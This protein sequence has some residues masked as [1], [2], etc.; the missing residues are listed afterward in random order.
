MERYTSVE[1]EGVTEE[2]APLRLQAH[3]WQARILQHECDHVQVCVW[4]VGGVWGAVG[5]QLLRGEGR[6]LGGHHLGMCHPCSL[7]ISR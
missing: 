1:V 7:S 4:G 3:G 5:L 2:G 6:Q